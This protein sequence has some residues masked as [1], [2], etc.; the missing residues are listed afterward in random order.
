MPILI[1]GYNLLYAYCG[2]THQMPLKNLEQAREELLDVLAHYRRRQRQKITVYFD[3]R[4]RR[5][6]P[7]DSSPRGVDVIYVGP[8][9]DA[10]TAIIEAVEKSS[11]SRSLRIVSSDREVVRAARRRRA[12]TVGSG[13]FAQELLRALKR[14]ERRGPPEPRMKFEGPSKADV[15][16]WLKI[17]EEADS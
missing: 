2:I 15:E 12:P 11:H 17:F 10:D 6:A 7:P 14:S 13:A 5:G 4:R 1:D 3:G 8:E 16:Y 9:S